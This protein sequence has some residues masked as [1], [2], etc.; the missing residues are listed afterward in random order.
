[1]R[2]FDNGEIDAALTFPGLIDTLDDAFRSDAVLPPRSHYDVKRPDGDPAVLLIMPAWSA[3]SAEKAYIGTKI[4][5]VF[6]GNG[7]RNLPGVMGAYLLMDGNTGQPLAVMDGNRL[8]LWRTA[9]ASALAARYMAS[10]DASRMLMVGAGSL[11]PFL[12]KAHRAVR[13][14]TDIAI[15]AR[16]PE[17]AIAVVEELAR[18]GIEARAV[19]DLE[20]EARTADIISCATNAS[21]PLIQGKWLKRDAHLDL[22]G[23]FT[24]QMREADAE[25]LNRARVIVDSR[26][27]IDEGGDVAVAIAEGSYSADRIAGTLADL[28]HGRIAGAAEGGEITLF[29]SVGASLEDL[30]AAVAVWEASASA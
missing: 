14:L 21:E 4:V 1:M 26:K 18:D 28:C 13:P 5:S 16:R 2:L 30:A 17:A 7:K 29:K 20:A 8:T 25:A 27:A 24:M 15:W 19:T 10:P 3:P 11:A 22:I 12:V 23:A 9:A 6:F